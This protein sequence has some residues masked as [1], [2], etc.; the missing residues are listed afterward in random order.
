M[1]RPEENLEGYENSSVIPRAKDLHGSLL[2]VY[3]SYDD[4]VHPVNGEAF[5]D[6][7]IAAGKKF[8]RMTYP[9]RQHGI[10]DKAATLH[11][12]RLMV[13]FWKAHL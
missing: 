5:A 3:G 13:D 7:L 12:Y 8:E 2:L 9:M 11:L 10:A 6:A 4:N 1:R